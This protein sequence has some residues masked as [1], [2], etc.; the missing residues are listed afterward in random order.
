MKFRN[1]QRP[2][3]VYMSSQNAHLVKIWCI[4]FTSEIIG[5][6]LI[7]R[8]TLTRYKPKKGLQTEVFVLKAHSQ[9]I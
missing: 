9:L 5:L 4:M 3:T 1:K 8:G 6:Y 2:T 7:S